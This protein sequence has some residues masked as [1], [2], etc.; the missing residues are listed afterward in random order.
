MN[1]QKGF[2]IIEVIIAIIVLTVGL[3][4]L[5][6]SAALVTRMIARGQRSAVAST[7]A[8][9]RMERLRPAACIAAQRV[10]GTET[11]SR[12]STVVATNTWTFTNGSGQTF[13][14]QVITTYLTV[15]NRSRT[16][17]LE[18]SVSCLT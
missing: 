11:L 8:A 6:S 15:K 4:G 2:T 5:V 3:L 14:I 9:Q 10:G 7:F 18:T 16:D 1:N 17:T 12:G 13:R